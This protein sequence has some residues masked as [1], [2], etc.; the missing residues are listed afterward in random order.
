MSF[1]KI[2]NHGTSELP[3][4]YVCA[5]TDQ[6]P[7]ENIVAG[8]TAWEYDTKKGYVFADGGWREV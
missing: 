5:S 7:T 3:E 1:T 4:E 8:S 6:K 2:A